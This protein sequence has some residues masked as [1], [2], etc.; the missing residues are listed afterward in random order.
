MGGANCICSDKTGTLTQ[1]KMSLVEIWNKKPHNFNEFEKHDLTADP[2]NIKNDSTVNLLKCSFVCN[3]SAHG[4]RKVKDPES[5]TGWKEL[6]PSG[7]KTEIA[8][9]N[10]MDRAGVDYAALRE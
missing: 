10:F 4:K 2:F 1:N 5:K 3:A 8:L 9:V 7:N 6:E